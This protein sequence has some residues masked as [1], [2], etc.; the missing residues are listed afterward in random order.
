MLKNLQKEPYLWGLTCEGSL[1]VWTG[2]ETKLQVDLS[3]SQFL[4]VKLPNL[5]NM[6]YMCGIWCYIQRISFM[7]SVYRPTEIA[8][9]L[10]SVYRPTEFAIYLHFIHFFI[11]K[12][13]LHK[14]VKNSLFI[15][16]FRKWHFIHSDDNNQSLFVKSLDVETCKSD[17]L[18]FF[19]RY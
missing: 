15:Y 1:W 16:L 6:H 9:Y 2:R 7:S 11:V 13:S 19:I 10:F 17:M 8:I 5:T 3:N 4:V 18:E 14:S 12:E